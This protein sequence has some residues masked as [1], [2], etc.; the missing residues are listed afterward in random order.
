MQVFF[1]KAILPAILPNLDVAGPRMLAATGWIL[2]A[3]GIVMTITPLA[4]PVLSDRFGETRVILGGVAASSVVLAALG[5][6]GS[7]W[8]FAGLW[9]VH[10]VA[11][12]PIFSLVTARAALWTSGQALGF[13]NIF[14]VL[15]TFAGPVVATTLM[16][17][18]NGPAMFALFGIIG[19]LVVLVVSRMWKHMTVKAT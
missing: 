7:L 15:A 3:T 2:F 16:A 4:G 5:L 8:T 13:V 17:W 11:I 6:A 9:L 14:R 1:L 10:V 18:W 19:L 12:A